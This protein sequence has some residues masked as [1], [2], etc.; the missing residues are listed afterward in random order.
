MSVRRIRRAWWHRGENRTTNIIAN[1]YGTSYMASTPED[2][3]HVNSLNFYDKSSHTLQME[4]EAQS[5]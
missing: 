3:I 1:I 4:I 5:V 2:F